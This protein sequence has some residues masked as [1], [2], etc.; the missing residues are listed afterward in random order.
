[1]N[2]SIPSPTGPTVDH[3]VVPL[4]FT[5]DLPSTIVSTGDAAEY[6]KHTGYKRLADCIAQYIE[7]NGMGDIKLEYDNLRQCFKVGTRILVLEKKD[8]ASV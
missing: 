1:M 6:V 5:F 2:Y 4:A 8:N 7:E 3:K